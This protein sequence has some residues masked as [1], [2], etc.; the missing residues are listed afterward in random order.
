MIEECPRLL[1]GCPVTLVAGENS[2]AEKVAED[3]SIPAIKVPS[4]CYHNNYTSGYIQ[5]H[6]KASVFSACEQFE[7]C[8]LSTM[9]R[10]LSKF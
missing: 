4:Y 3:I 8:Q 2:S 7:I 9:S 6:N 5:A 10:S 1:S